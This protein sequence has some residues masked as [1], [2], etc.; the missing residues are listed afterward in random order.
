MLGCATGENVVKSFLM[1][2]ARL[3]PVVYIVV[4]IWGV[5]TFFM[6]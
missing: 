2:T 5:Y 1:N 3:K 6:I 4:G